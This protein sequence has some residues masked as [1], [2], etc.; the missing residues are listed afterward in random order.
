MPFFLIPDPFYKFVGIFH[1]YT[2][3]SLTFK[4]S[5]IDIRDFFIN[6]IKISKDLHLS[7]SFVR[8]LR[9]F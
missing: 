6:N 8:Y 3:F 5:K 4:I 7:R 1:T 9:R 2:K